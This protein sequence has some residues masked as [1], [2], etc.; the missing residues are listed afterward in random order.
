MEIGLSLGSN[1]GDRVGHLAQA[2]HEIGALP[3]TRIVAQ[4]P[5]YET[6]PV[7]VRAE[8]RHLTFLNG[9]LV[10]E[11]D[12]PLKDA[13]R[14]LAALELKLGRRRE[15]NKFA[16]R[17]ID[18]DLLYAGDVFMETEDLTIPHPRWAERRFVLLPLADVRPNLVLPG[19]RQTVRGMLDERPNG[20][21]VTLVTREW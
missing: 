20:E 15:L 18:I 7:G 1:L 14:E 2:R 11:T 19:A 4:S 9:V 8:H 17:T 12:L 5:L 16:P 6:E 3:R 21:K 13:Q 10:I